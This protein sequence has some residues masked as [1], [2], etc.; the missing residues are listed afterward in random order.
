[1]TPSTPLRLWPG[2]VFGLLAAAL[3]FVLPALSSDLI[4]VGM[5]GGL[6]CAVLVVLWWLFFSRAPWLE[7]LGVLAFM[8]VAVAI[9]YQFVHKSIA[10]GMMGFMLPFYSLPALAAALG[11]ATWVSRRADVRGRRLAIATGVVSACA[12]FLLLRTDG[13]LNGRAELKWRWTP[14]AE[15]KLLAQADAA[16]PPAQ[17]VTAAAPAP[18]L[19]VTVDGARP[20]DAATNPAA[21]DPLTATSSSAA[22]ATNVAPAEWPGFRGVLRDGVVPNVRIATDWTS[23]PPV[24]IWKRAIGP[25]WSSFAVSGDLLY[26]Q[27]QRGEDEV[28]AAYSVS[29]GKPVWAHRDA[30][31]FWESNGGAGP[32]G[33]PTVANGRVYAFGATGILNALDARTGAKLW[34]KN[35]AQDT[36]TKVPGWGFS[37]SPIVSG[38]VVV[39]AAAG[40]LAGYDATTGGQRWLG[41]RHGGSYSSPHLVTIDGVTQVVMLSSAGATSVAPATGDVLWEHAWEG[42]AIVQPAVLTGGD[43]LVNA[44]TATGGIGVRRLK[45]AHASGTW[46]ADEQWTS[47]G[48]KPYFNDFVVHK[49]HAFGFDG[50][51]LACINLEDGKRVWKGGRYGSGQLVLLPEQ[52]LLLVLSEEGDLALVNARPDKFTEV[53]R[54]PAIEGKTWNHPAIVGDVV[55]VRN[56]EQMAAYRL[57]KGNK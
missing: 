56:G 54:A 20:G 55:L 39:V 51:I 24:A 7:R 50:S 12:L 34:S 3:W 26:T 35:V 38:D 16:L 1:M 31:R 29:T 11:I 2:S 10:G 44:I 47:S 14:N 36:D 33:T 52:D 27:E 15:E 48:L 49:G 30:V 37:S 5:F 46:R 21:R 53:A 25:G 18:G 45:L 17:P 13:I 6:I 42:G 19:V 43:I 23:S 40:N 22:V 4:G 32:R 57:P 9:T 41:P 28:V 8:A